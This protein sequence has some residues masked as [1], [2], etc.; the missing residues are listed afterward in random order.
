MTVENPISEMV[1]V[2]IRAKN[3]NGWSEWS[4]RGVAR[5][6]E[7]GEKEEEDPL[8]ELMFIHSVEQFG[9]A[10]RKMGVNSVEQML[11]LTS[12]DVASGELGER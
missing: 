5:R 4:D 1:S 3:C 8:A 7:A 11:Q 10:V 6:R 12:S 2:R 9:E